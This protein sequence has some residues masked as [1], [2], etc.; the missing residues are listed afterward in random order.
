MNHRQTDHPSKKMCR[1]FLKDE[2]IFDEVTC[3]YKH[4][5]Q[6][7]QESITEG[8]VHTCRKCDVTT[9]TR[10]ELMHHIKKTHRETLSICRRFREGNCERGEDYCWF[11]HSM[12]KQEKTEQKEVIVGNSDFQEVSKKIPP[13][14]RSTL[15]EMITKL[16]LQVEKL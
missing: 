5:T 16:T 3:W 4:Y 15:L 10:N 13:D 1:Y 11:S 6:L 9:E 7:E 12:E 8:I 14:Q 2:C